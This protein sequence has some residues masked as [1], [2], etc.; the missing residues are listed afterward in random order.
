MQSQSSPELDFAAIIARAIAIFERMRPDRRVTPAGRDVLIAWAD[1]RRAR[2]ETE[3][4]SGRVQPAQLEQWALGQLE[5]A[6]SVHDDIVALLRTR[7]PG[8][9][10]AEYGPAIYRLYG[11]TAAFEARA[12]QIGAFTI[13][14]S[15]VRRCNFP[16]FKPADCTF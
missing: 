6:S 8:S 9:L 15:M 12:G 10:Q 2:I 7:G 13:A 4:V 14:A 5:A 3:V 16:P 11:S 1:Q